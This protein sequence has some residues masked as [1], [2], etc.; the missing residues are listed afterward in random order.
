M[1]EGRRHQRAFFRRKLLGGLVAGV[2]IIPGQADLDELAAEHPG[3]VDLLLRRRHRHEHHALLAE[4][5]AHIGKALGVI[6]RRGADEQRWPGRVVERLADEIERAANLVGSDRREIFP[7]EPDAGAIAA[8]QV[9][10][11]LKW[12]R[13][14]QR[15]HL[16]KRIVHRG[17][18]LIG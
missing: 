1:V 7:L 4:M 17:T 10:V 2:E 14:E 13:C 6:A 12:R 18:E 11:E 16:A 15:P 8:G 3:L 5:P 9:V